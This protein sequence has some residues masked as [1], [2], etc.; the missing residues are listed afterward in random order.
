MIPSRVVAAPGV[1][2][3]ASPGW[4]AHLG[5]AL[6]IVV[7][8][9]QLWLVGALGFALR[10]GFVV[11]LLPILVLPTPVEVRL[12]LGPALGSSGL[13]AEFW[14]VVAAGSAVCAGGLIG[15]L[16]AIAWLELSAFDQLVRDPESADL[17]DWRPAP[18]LSS[19]RR[20]QVL[21]WI[22]VAQSLALLAI[23]L[24]ALP[25]A[26]AIGPAILDEL[27]RPS[28]SGPLLMRVTDRV[29]PQIVA[30]IAATVVVETLSA[31][32]TRHLLARE[33]GLSSRAARR[34]G[35]LADGLLFAAR[36][37]LR[38]PAAIA[39]TAGTG[40]LVSAMVIAPALL[41]LSAVWQTTRA[42]FLS[43]TSVADLL[44][45]PEVL[46]V[47]ALLA[48]V[49]LAAL[50]LAGLASAIRAASW[51]IELLRQGADDEP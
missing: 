36:R 6:A 50:V 2:S 25:L 16:L 32:A 17:R 40:W 5:I 44:D 33:Y 39:A 30:V 46:F 31:V 19:A 11:L 29:V 4:R 3:A 24:S 15:L 37:I 28:S 51:T 8:R 14:T 10:G 49:M 13:T 48:A 1:R 27:V 26:A 43:T 45:H 18:A 47:A 35:L 38:A 9:P 7:G 42:S 34:R 23:V 21:S 41:A 20:R 22:F 12:L